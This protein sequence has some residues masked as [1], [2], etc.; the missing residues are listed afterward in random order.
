ML[1]THCRNRVALRV[2]FVRPQGLEA[3]WER[4]SLWRDAQQIPGAAVICDS[5]EV[6]AAR[7]GAT[8][9]GETFLYDVDGCLLF[10]GG[11]TAA[12]GHQG[13]S[14]GR[15]VLTALIVQG[16]AD[17]AQSPVFGCALSNRSSFPQ[18]NETP[19]AP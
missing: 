2:V 9:S 15:A 8:T 18:G 4:S 13:D 11:V 1:A 6:E 10:R 17:Q 19:C 14:L 5:G 7:F 3:G 12:R 16:H